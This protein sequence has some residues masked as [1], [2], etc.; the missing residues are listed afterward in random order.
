MWGAV[1]AVAF[2]LLEW[3]LD[4]KKMSAEAKKKFFEFVKTVGEEQKSVKLMK[5][6]DAQIAWRE[7]HGWEE[8]K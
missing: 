7:E 6:A 4:S 5:Y 3:W 1:I 8:T 2:K